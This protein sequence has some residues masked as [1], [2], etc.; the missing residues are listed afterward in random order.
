M[1]ICAGPGESSPARATMASMAS[2]RQVDD[3]LRASSSCGSPA[4]RPASTAGRRS[5][6]ARRS[7]PPGRGRG[8][9]RGRLAVGDRPGVHAQHADGDAAAQVLGDVVLVGRREDRAGQRELRRRGVH[10]VAEARQH[11]GGPLELEERDAAE[12]L[13]RQ[14]MERELERR[15]D[16]EGA[17]AAAQ[18]PQQV[19]VLVG[20]RAHDRAVP[21]H[22]L[23]GEQVVAGQ[24]VLA[25]QPARAAAQRQPGD[26]GG[27]DAAAGRRQPVAARWRG[28]PAPRSRR[29]R[30]A[31]RGA[32][33]R[34]RR[35]PCRAGRARCRR[36]TASGRRP[37]GRR[38][39][40]RSAGRARAPRP[41][42]RPRRRRR[43]AARRAAGRRSIMALKR[44][45]ASS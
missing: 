17:A 29:R 5:R 8:S 4:G 20:G 21:R 35:R 24:A 1:K 38:R 40:R 25:L 26:A 32:A 36:R 16:A 3:V 42:S 13:G 22:Q 10:D 41:G 43:A 6:S 11:L 39:A 33:G 19:G 45:Q 23:G 31:R 9:A 30:C 27:G 12:H 7:R 34:P 44:V 28:R 37:S 15:H 2:A 14:R 18:R